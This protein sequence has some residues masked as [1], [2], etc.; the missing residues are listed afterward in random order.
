MIHRPVLPG[1]HHCGSHNG[2]QSSEGQPVPVALHNGK[3]C[4]GRH[5]DIPSTL[6]G[7]G[8]VQYPEGGGSGTASPEGRQ[9]SDARAPAWG[10]RRG[11]ARAPASGLSGLLVRR[12]TETIRLS[13][14]HCHEGLVKYISAE[15]LLLKKCQFSGMTVMKTTVT[16]ARAKG[17]LPLPPAGSRGSPALPLPTPN[18]A[19][20][21]GSAFL[22]CFLS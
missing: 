8:C 13:C 20:T 1:G 21:G 15:L 12:G 14:K 4:T 6:G 22:G 7:H 16:Y 3:C 10:W 17:S 11:Q 19:D 2:K 18:P 5:W 9:G